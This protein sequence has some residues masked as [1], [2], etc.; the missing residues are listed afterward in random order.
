[1]TTR[2][3]RSSHAYSSA[4]GS[5]WSRR[6]PGRRRVDV[7]RQARARDESTPFILMS[8]GIEPGWR[9]AEDG[10]DVIALDKPFS[11]AALREAI[12]L[13]VP[14]AA[15]DERGRRR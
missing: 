3:A 2:S 14:R 1:M 9:D 4:T 12:A 7:M 13:L 6:R 5:T 15:G 8:A 11:L 10:S